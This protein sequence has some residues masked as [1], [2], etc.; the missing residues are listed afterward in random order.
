MA[1]TRKNYQIIQKVG[2]DEFIVL[3]PETDAGNVQV[4]AEGIEASTVKGALEELHGQIDEITGGGVVTGIKGEAED[5]FHQGNV[6]ITKANIGLGNVNN[7]ADADKPVSTAQQA[8][9]NLKEDKSKLKALAYKDSLAK[10]DVGLGNVTNDAQ[11]K[12]SEMGV[13]NG[14]ATLGEDGKVP[15]AQLP[16]YVDDVIEGTYV[17][18]TTFNG[19][20][21]SP[22]TPE[23]GKIYVDTTTNKEYRWGGTKFAV[24]SES[25]A[26][27]ETAS[28]AYAG[29]KGKQNATD[30][31]A[32][33]TRV[34]SVESKNTQQDT[35]ITAAQEAADGAQEAAEAAASAASAADTKATTAQTKANTNETNITKITNG[36]T[37][38][39]K[40]GT[41]DSATAA[42][43]LST[44]RTIAL[45]GDATGSTTFDGSANKDITVTLANS[46]VQAG[47]YS[48]VTVDAKG[49]VTAGGQLV[50]VGTEG[51]STPSANLAT[52]GLFFK[53]I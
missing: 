44:A 27:G 43:K 10:G 53:L 28:T 45:K 39:G 20:G 40:A 3:L 7:T 17:N 36:T 18:E 2:E 21:G 37:K 47:S 23:S 9:L 52:G 16:S 11:V 12:R 30:I 48:A 6:T 22:V 5:E 34:G 19:A 49:R 29:D 8:A 31:A 15:S 38:V 25:I 42:G 51:Q 4:E 26:L 24:I 13:A 14:V 46:G 32:L 41:A 1:T 33:K 50:E 35:A